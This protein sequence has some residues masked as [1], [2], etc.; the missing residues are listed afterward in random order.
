MSVMSD[1]SASES[2]T[3]SMPPA[4]SQRLPNRSDRR[5]AMGAVTMISTVIGRNRTPVSSGERR[6]MSCM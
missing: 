2:D 1:S 3:S 4:R 5:P 6:R